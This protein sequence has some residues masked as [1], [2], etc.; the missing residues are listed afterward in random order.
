V[1]LSNLIDTI[2]RFGYSAPFATVHFRLARHRGANPVWVASSVRSSNPSN[3]C[4]GRALLSAPVS[5]FGSF[6]TA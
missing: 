3:R 6:S 4:F 1:F 5:I 2:R